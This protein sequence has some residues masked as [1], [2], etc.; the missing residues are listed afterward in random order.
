MAKRRRITVQRRE[1][2]ARVLNLRRAG[3]TYEQ[4]AAQ[5]GISK[6]QVA[7]DV[8]DGLEEVTREPAEQVLQLE[9]DR[10]DALFLGVYDKGRKGSVAHI[11]RALKIMDRRAKYLGLDTPTGA[12]DV[13]AVK[14]GLERLI[15]GPTA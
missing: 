1:R 8:K 15:E 13:Q 11:D 3:A 7:L 2:M 12:D 5:L 10:L 9:L 14:S 6:T 4:I